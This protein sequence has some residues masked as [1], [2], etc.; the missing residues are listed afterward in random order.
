[1]QFTRQWLHDGDKNQDGHCAGSRDAFTAAL[2]F[3][4]LQVGDLG[5]AKRVEDIG[6]PVFSPN[7][8]EC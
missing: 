8:F 4:E 3:R 5:L 1:L 6:E 7:L 2:A